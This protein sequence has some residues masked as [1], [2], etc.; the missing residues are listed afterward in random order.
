MFHRAV[1]MSDHDYFVIFINFHTL[2]HELLSCVVPPHCKIGLVC[3]Q[4]TLFHCENIKTL[5]SVT[6]F[7]LLFSPHIPDQGVKNE[8]VS[9]RIKCFNRIDKTDLNNIM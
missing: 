5:I 6:E 8:F 4:T 1:Y 2:G 7:T 3:G 9:R